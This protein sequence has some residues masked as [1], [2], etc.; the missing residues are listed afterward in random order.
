MINCK[1]NS[2]ITFDKKYTPFKSKILYFNLNFISQN[3]Q[4]VSQ[5]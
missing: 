1:K 2:L 5:L 4:Y 3:V